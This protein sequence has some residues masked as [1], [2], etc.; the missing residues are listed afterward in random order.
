M[1]AETASGTFEGQVIVN[2]GRHMTIETATGQQIECRIKG[3]RLRP[4]CG[5]FVSGERLPDG[6][7][8]IKLI[9][10]RHALL[11]RHDARLGNV[12]LAANVDRMLVV[13]APKPAAEPALI[14]RYLVAAENLGIEA[15]LLLNKLDLPGSVGVRDVLEEFA[16]IGYPVLQVSTVDGTGIAALGEVLRH[17]TGVVVGQSGTGKSSLLKALVPTAEIRIGEISSASEEGR[18]TTTVSALYR[19]PNGGKLIDSPGVRG[20]QLW[21]MPVRQLAQGFIEFR[22]STGTC[23]FSDCRH[24]HEPGCGVRASLERGEISPRRY[25][26]YRSLCRQ[27]AP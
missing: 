6:T 5:D 13:V 10:E 19:L 22:A 20:F 23:R 16:A 2:F 9:Q 4:V 11:L 14:D 12:A 18:H 21:P 15:L 17:H 1:P 3:R 26:S 8:R 27:L 24:L 7:G 25:E